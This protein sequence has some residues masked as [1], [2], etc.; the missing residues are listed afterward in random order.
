MDEPFSALDY[1]TRQHLQKLVLRLFQDSRKTIVFVTHDVE[2][3]LL[4]GDRLLVMET[5]SIKADLSLAFP[6]PRT[7]ADP[8]FQLMRQ[9]ILQL[10][11]ECRLLLRFPEPLGD[12]CGNDFPDLNKLL[13]CCRVMAL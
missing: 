11:G 1:F 13:P 3:A 7:A 6:R 9:K 4:L 12:V 10:L 2:E 8:E 5:G